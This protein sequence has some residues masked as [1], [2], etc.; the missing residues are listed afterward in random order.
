MNVDT[1]AFQ[2]LT[3]QVAGLAEQVGGLAQREIA[4]K[5]IFQAGSRPARTTSAGRRSSR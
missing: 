2:A 1:G 5:A 3:A 4:V